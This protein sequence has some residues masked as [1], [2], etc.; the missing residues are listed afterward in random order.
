MLGVAVLRLMLQL[1]W[2]F[3]LWLGANQVVEQLCRL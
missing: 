1:M 3:E 2:R